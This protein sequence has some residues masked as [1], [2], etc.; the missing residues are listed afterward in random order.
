[1]HRI[2][3]Q[4]SH[5][6]AATLGLLSVVAAGGPL[7]GQTWEPVGPPGGVAG[8]LTV[9]PNP[10]GLVYM[11]ANVP[12]NLGNT[13][14]RSV[15]G[16]RSWRTVPG[17]QVADL[18]AVDPRN[19]A[20]LYGQLISGGSL[21]LAKSLDGGRHWQFADRGLQAAETAQAIVQLVVDP[22]VDSRLYVPTGIGLYESDDGAASWHLSAFAGVVVTQLAI[23]P[24]NPLHRFAAV[25]LPVAGSCDPEISLCAFAEVME[26]HD[27]GRTWA[28]T[29]FR[30]LEDVGETPPTQLVIGPGALYALDGGAVFRRPAG[31][32]WAATATLP[33]PVVQ[34][35][36]SPA[37]QLYAGGFGVYTSVDGGASWQPE[38]A[39][40]APFDQVSSLAV[41]PDADETVLASSFDLTWR[42]VNRGD[43]WLPATA[44][45]PRWFV[46]AVAVGADSAVYSGVQFRGI[47]RSADQGGS[48]QLRSQGLKLQV[49]PFT[50]DQESY[51]VD[52]IA[53]DPTN[54]AI[55]YT[56]ISRTVAD[57]GLY[58]TTDS[59]RSWQLLPHLPAKPN[60]FPQILAVS[61]AAPANLYATVAEFA[62][63]EGGGPTYVLL[64]S[65][66]SG[67]HWTRL[68]EDTL[69]IVAFA[70]DPRQARTLYALSFAAGLKKST[71][72]GAT[73]Q[74][75]GS[76][77]LGE[78][79]DSDGNSV[80]IDPQR[81][82]T[83]YVQVTTG[84]YVSHD[85]GATF[86]PM[87]GG[88]AAPFSCQQLVID[89]QT[90]DNLYL[91][92]GSTILRW[93]PDLDTWQ[94]LAAGLPDISLF[95]TAVLTIDPRHPQVLYLATNGRGVYRLDLGP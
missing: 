79:V 71:D 23:D 49:P 53:A 75:A 82:T 77:G 17:Q 80:V 85:G 78:V 13:V 16:G 22:V 54:P 6:V 94:P 26:S 39:T 56:F 64:H 55:L 70:A 60:G 86:T 45:P 30:N 62:D 8:S 95:S 40:A 1:M 73:W 50:E 14:F 19:G 84:V 18:L 32:R 57:Y 37:G 90:P 9:A 5:A 83:L 20:T 4:F 68:L 3:L 65:A 27:G 88:L 93:R 47:E 7:A 33:Q 10:A 42:S 51:V 29:G 91:L 89:P 72:G 28:S 69:P 43:S 52:T 25:V 92:T 31:R 2:S 48:W 81:S 41:L 58:R 59:G 34:L 11:A 74:N 46:T 67:K 36:I 61:S 35:A 12:P 15:D 38:S 66:D 24:G 63:P 87:N 44:G 21:R 76:A